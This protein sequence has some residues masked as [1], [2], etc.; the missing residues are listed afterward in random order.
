MNTNVERDF[1]ICISIPSVTSLN[2]QYIPN[3]PD[4]NGNAE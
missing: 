3:F 2:K 4:I 1:E